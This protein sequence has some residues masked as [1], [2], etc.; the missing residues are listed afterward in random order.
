M[1][2]GVSGR[3]SFIPSSLSETFAIPGAGLASSLDLTSCI[4]LRRLFSS[5]ALYLSSATLVLHWWYSCRRLSRTSR[6]KYV[7]M[8][9]GISD[10]CWVCTRKYI[11]VARGNDFVSVYRN[12]PRLEIV[13]EPRCAMLIV[14]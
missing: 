11:V 6:E 10:C 5:V 12:A 13:F 7:S 8:L 3:I 1:G 4:S 14:I 2:F 9:S